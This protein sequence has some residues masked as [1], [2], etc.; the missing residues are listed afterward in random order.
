[1]RDGDVRLTAK[2]TIDWWEIIQIEVYMKSHAMAQIGRQLRGGINF[3]RKRSCALK[4]LTDKMLLGINFC[5]ISSTFRRRNDW[6]MVPRVS[7]S[8][9]VECI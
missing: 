4:Y 9:R 5:K 6:I 2:Q 3:K 8:M 1:M 7:A